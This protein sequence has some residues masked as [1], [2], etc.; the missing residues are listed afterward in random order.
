MQLK[1]IF[2]G[3]TGIG[4]HMLKYLIDL[5]MDI[6][7]VFTRPEPFKHP[8]FPVPSIEEISDDFGIPYSYDLS[9]YSCL[10]FD[11]ILCSTYHK[12]IPIEIISKAKLGAFNFHPSLLPSYQGASPTKQCLLNGEIATGITVHRMNAKLDKGEIISQRLIKIEDYFDDGF[13]RQH[14]AGLQYNSLIDLLKYLEGD[15]I[16][17]H[18][19]NNVS[20]Y[21]PPFKALKVICTPELSI[22]KL[23]REI[24]ASAPFPG[25]TL[26]TDFGRYKIE[27]QIAYKKGRYKFSAEACGNIITVAGS[28]GILK[29]I[30]K[31]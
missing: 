20:S 10:K 16:A 13:L 7:K 14:L 2:F 21:Y 30:G 4:S 26:V 3:L 19:K 6:Q 22:V 18:Q 12:I 5:G 29:A 28:N 31:K 11:I 15:G 24:R 25:L 9:D 17:V 23:S 27:R 1:M 8:Y